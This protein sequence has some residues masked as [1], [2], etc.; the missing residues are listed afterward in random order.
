MRL[1]SDSTAPVSQARIH[2]AVFEQVGNVRLPVGYRRWEH[3]GTRIKADGFSVLDGSKITTPQVMDAYV[4]PSA[5]EVFEKTGKWPDGTQLIKEY[6]LIENGTN[7]SATNFVCSTVFGRG[8]FEDHYA[9][10]GMILG[11]RAAGAISAFCR[12]AESISYP[13]VRDRANNVPPVTKREQ[14]KQTT[15]LFE[16]PHWTASR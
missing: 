4:E 10:M 5:Y 11:R 9:G 14:Q 15:F 3:V 12:L 8:I 7:C 13:L 2:R 16:K 1:E 6:S